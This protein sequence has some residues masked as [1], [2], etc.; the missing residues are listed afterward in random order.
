[1][2]INPNYPKDNHFNNKVPQTTCRT[3][4]M[5]TSFVSAIHTGAELVSSMTFDVQEKD[6]S[7]KISA[8]MSASVFG[9]G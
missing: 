7:Q 6:E 3:I 2:I 1:M 8:A 9:L 5:F 4:P